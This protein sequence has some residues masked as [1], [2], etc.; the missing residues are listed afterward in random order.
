MFG[1]MVSVE[2]N[3]ILFFYFF[4]H[5]NVWVNPAPFW[6]LSTPGAGEITVDLTS[7][8]L[9]LNLKPDSNL[10]S[11]SDSDPSQNQIQSEV[12]KSKLASTT[13]TLADTTTTSLNTGVYFIK[14][15]YCS[16]LFVLILVK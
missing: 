3:I 8:D 1:F 6:S 10:R 5:R 16:T 13:T 4:L 14:F 7:E 9:T 12:T 2:Y 11:K 15:M